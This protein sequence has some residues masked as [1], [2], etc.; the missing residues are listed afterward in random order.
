MSYF[1]IVASAK[2]GNPNGLSVVLIK[3]ETGSLCTIPTYIPPRLLEL[4]I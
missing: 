1:V 3:Q 4:F 2:E